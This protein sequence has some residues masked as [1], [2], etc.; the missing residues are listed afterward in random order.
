[1][2]PGDGL[3]DEIDWRE[4]PVDGFSDFAAIAVRPLSG[5]GDVLDGLEASGNRRSSGDFATLLRH[6]GRLV[7]RRRPLTTAVYTSGDIRHVRVADDVVGSRLR[8]VARFG[9]RLAADDP[10]DTRRA[11]LDLDTRGGERGV[12][13]TL[14]IL[15]GRTRAGPVQVFLRVARFTTAAEVEDDPLFAT[16]EGRDVLPRVDDGNGFRDVIAVR[17]ETIVIPE[18]DAPDLAGGTV[19]G[20]R[21]VVD[22]AAGVVRV[23]TDELGAL[24]A[25]DSP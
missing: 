8:R 19:V 12:I 21:F 24:Q 23:L 6:E 2:G 25:F 15:G 17:Y 3:G 18:N 22:A 20:K 7:G 9:P 4:E 13:V 11:G 16:D 1:V 14:P 5:A 10:F